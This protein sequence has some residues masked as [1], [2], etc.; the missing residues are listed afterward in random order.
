[1]DV[2]CG[3][4]CCVFLAI[5]IVLRRA[6]ASPIRSNRGKQLCKGFGGFWQV[7]FCEVIP[8]KPPTASKMFLNLGFWASQ[9]LL[10][11]IPPPCLCLT[12]NGKMQHIPAT[13]CGFHFVHPG[14]R[15]ITRN[16]ARVHRSL[17]SLLQ[18]QTL[19][20]CPPNILIFPVPILHGCS[21]LWPAE[22][23]RGHAVVSGDIF[24]GHFASFW[25]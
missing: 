18:W 19:Q 8:K 12:P 14:L 2:I 22:P 3:V 15:Y 1:M 21:S 9:H 16:F 7:T 20:T 6:N 24:C 4:F 10:A 17:Y 11:F 23:A 25:R 13:H 5:E